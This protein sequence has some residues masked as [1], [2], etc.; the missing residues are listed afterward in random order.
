V[1]RAA[2]EHLPFI[3]DSRVI[4]ALV[5]SLADASPR[6][7]GAAARAFGYVE[8]GIA[9]SHL[10]A[11]LDDSDPWVRYF[12]ARSIGRHAR[13]EGLDLLGRVAQS[14]AAGFARV[15]AIEAIGQIGGPRAVA[16][17]TP[18][19][20]AEDRDLSRAALVALG[21]TR[22]PDALP[23]LLAA[24]RSPD[25]SRREDAIR[26]LSE[27]G[28]TGIADSLQWVAAADEEAQVAQA[29]IDS[30]AGLATPEAIAALTELT[31]DAGR[32]EACVA[33]LAQ[34]SRDRID[35]IASGL[36]HANPVVRCAVI[37]ALTRMK[38]PLASELLSVAL[39]DGEAAVR[40]AGATALGHL[41][42]RAAERKLS[43]LAATDPDVAVR[44]AAQKALE[45]L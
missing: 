4:P 23:P 38:H 17:L 25:I 19:T 20:A 33:A 34:L 27:H 30:L 8:S 12:A 5:D 21:A 29:A 1:R 2:I 42:S 39:D 32:R 26:A 13:D 22:H 28:G 3:E 14:D 35:L 40:L 41:G 10:L 44:C 36:D 16:I 31:A 6:L 37:D 18:L 11:A 45:K 43:S 15:A 9:L 7:R 24:L